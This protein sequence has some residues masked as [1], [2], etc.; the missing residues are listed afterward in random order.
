MT[1]T[2]L[3][4]QKPSG[5]SK[6]KDNIKKLEERLKRWNE[7]DTEEIIQRLEQFKIFL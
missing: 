7:G 3:L 1:L 5:N 2:C 6:A 4:L